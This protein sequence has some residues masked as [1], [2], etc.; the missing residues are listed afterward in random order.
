MYLENH[1]PKLHV[2][3][4]GNRSSPLAVADY[5]RRKRRVLNYRPSQEWHAYAT[6]TPAC[7]HRLHVYEHV[8]Y[9]TSIFP[10]IRWIVGGNMEETELRVAGE[11]SSCKLVAI[12]IELQREASSR[13]FGG[14]LVESIEV[15]KPNWAAAP[16]ITWFLAA[17]F[18]CSANEIWNSKCREDLLFVYSFRYGIKCNDW[19]VS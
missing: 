7:K 19:I 9:I 16:A 10:E 2:A 13:N 15:H 17:S 3:E 11:T 1:G 14:E 6:R 8:L 5:H 4:A 18:E 12:A